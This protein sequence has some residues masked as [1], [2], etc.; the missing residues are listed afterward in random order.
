VT[1]SGLH[2]LLT[3]RCTHECDHCFVWGGPRQAGT[4]TLEVVRGI[5]SQARGLAGLEWI[6]FEGGEP[7]L[8]YATLLAGAREAARLGFKV[9]IV[10]NA[11]W[12]TSAEDARE[13]LAPFAGLVRDLSLSCDALH[14]NDADGGTVAHAEAAAV[15][16]GIP[17]SRICVA[18]PVSGACTDAG[19]DG[20]TRG[21]I[22]AGR[23][24]VMF[25]GRAA[26]KLASDAPHRPA[27][28]FT[29]CPDEDLREPGRV[30]VDPFGNL[31]VCQGISI[32]NLF[33][34][35][36]REICRTYDPDSHPV[37]GPLLRGGPAE[38][39]R[40]A[41]LPANGFADACHAC[42]AARHAL[43][44]RHPDILCPDALYGSP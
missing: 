7:F 31:H 41:G 25:R 17:V 26:S 1:L 18:A 22:Q 43:R 21:Q 38:L 10:S 27:D 2:L 35:P 44:A 33:R 15:E 14:G 24:P 30:H 12:A 40:Q 37:I 29:S 16:L 23:S 4:M 36:L 39:V 13:S 6:Y 34:T 32:G 9:G 5:L 42:D 19:T 20:A 28:E 3:L 11:Y 8:F